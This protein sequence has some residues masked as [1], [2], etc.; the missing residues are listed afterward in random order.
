MKATIN[1][2]RFLEERG[3]ELSTVAKKGGFN[4]STILRWLL[5]PETVSA[6]KINALV[7][8]LAAAG[9]NREQIANTSL[10]EII[11]IEEEGE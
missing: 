7:S 8:F 5:Y 10:G 1:I 9:L 11:D 3:L 6:I 4:R 2:N